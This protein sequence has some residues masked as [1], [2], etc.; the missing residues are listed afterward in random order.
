[1]LRALRIHLDE[2]HPGAGPKPVQRQA[3]HQRPLEQGCQI[4]GDWRSR[5]IRIARLE[6]EQAGLPPGGARGDGDVGKAVGPPARL[7]HPAIGGVRLDRQH[8]SRWPHQAGGE[9]GESADIGADVDGGHARPENIPERSSDFRLVAAAGDV[10]ADGEIGIVRVD[11]EPVALRQLQ[12]GFG[13][14]APADALRM[15]RAVQIILDDGLQGLPGQAAMRTPL[16]TAGRPAEQ[17]AKAGGD[18]GFRGRGV[19]GGG[20]HSPDNSRRRRS[21]SSL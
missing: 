17:Q 19:Q 14:G 6:G 11:G 21:S 12:R 8:M 15:L 9:H 2:I 4:A 20:R 18:V 1:M 13:R 16:V 7:Q 3:G 10:A 5:A